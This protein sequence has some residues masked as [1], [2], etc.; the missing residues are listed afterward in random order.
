MNQTRNRHDLQLE[1]SFHQNQQ[2]AGV[3]FS[4]FLRC[5]ERHLAKFVTKLGLEIVEVEYE[6]NR[7]CE[8]LP[9]K[10]TSQ[11]ALV[12]C[13]DRLQPESCVP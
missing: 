2:N 8:L 3:V 9:Q 5:A 1:S 11:H 13:L 10:D 12:I 4:C 6:K 7:L